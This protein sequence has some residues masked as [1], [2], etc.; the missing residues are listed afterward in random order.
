MMIRLE[1]LK[2]KLRSRLINQSPREPNPE[3]GNTI[4]SPAQNKP[5]LT[6]QERLNQ[7]YSD[8]TQP[9]A[10]TLKIIKLL[11]NNER[12][13]LHARTRKPDKYRKI[14]SRY[15]GHILQMDLLEMGKFRGHNSL[16]K[17]TTKCYWIC[18]I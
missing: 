6:Q 15:P 5:N 1:L 7:R 2:M 4:Q 8:L 12:H 14:N 11:K 17:Y 9:A 3:S 18:P 10:Y 16:K 13:S